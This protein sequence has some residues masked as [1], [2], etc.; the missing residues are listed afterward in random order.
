MGQRL[1]LQEI[2]LTI[3]PNV[4]FQ[5]PESLKMEYPCIVYHRDYSNTEFADDRPY[6]HRKRYLVMVIDENPDSAIPTKVAELPMCLFD[7]FYTAKNLNHDVFKLF[8]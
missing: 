6:L 5:P 2:L 4:Y 1:D 7:R 3:V 8:F